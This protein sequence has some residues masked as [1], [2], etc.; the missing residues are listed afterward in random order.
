MV[1]IKGDWTRFSAFADK[2]NHF[3]LWGLVSSRAS[4]LCPVMVVD[5]YF[6]YPQP[7]EVVGYQGDSW[8]VIQLSDGYHAIHGSYLAEMQPKSGQDV[9]I[10]M[11]FAQ[12]LADYVV[13]D[14]ETT[15]YSRENDR[16]I[17]IGAA[18]YKY[19]EKT[20]EFQTYVNPERPIPS[21]IKKMTGISDADVAGA[22]GIAQAEMMFR[23]FV[24][25]RPLVGHNILTFDL[26]FL[27][28][29]FGLPIDNTIIDTLPMAKEAFPLLP[30]FKLEYL[31]QILGLGSNGHHRA[32]YDVEVTNS[33]LWACLAPRNYEQKVNRA[34]VDHVMAGAPQKKRHHPANKKI[35]IKE[36]KPSEPTKAAS[37]PLAGKTIVFTGELSM[38][39]REAMQIAVDAGAALK[40]AVS[41]KLSYLVIGKQDADLV[42]A[43]GMSSKEAAA[44]RLNE[45][46]KASIK[47]LT[48]EE[49]LRLAGRME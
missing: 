32:I 36:I 24:G 28:A 21:I 45:T 12:V 2:L 25:D 10:G 22:P 44:K 3:R 4:S 42:G 48:E 37:G 6:G 43:D 34:Y 41:G 49:F 5:G 33:L 35:D 39:R 47:L 46:G 9:S 20:D 16:I 40:S 19:G 8:A 30:N 18:A 13:I 7:C 15:G 1:P 23:A 26:P 11:K 31:D 14:I 17:E 27:S 29:H 38:P